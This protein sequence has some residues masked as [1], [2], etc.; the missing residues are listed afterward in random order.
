M[1]HYSEEV[2][3]ALALLGGDMV[4]MTDEQGFGYLPTKNWVGGLNE[5]AQSRTIKR[6]GSRPPRYWVHAKAPGSSVFKVTTIYLDVKATGKWSGL[7]ALSL[8]EPA[9]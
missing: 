5:M 6:I 2:A 9:S 4:T 3:T 8:S 1:P 7:H